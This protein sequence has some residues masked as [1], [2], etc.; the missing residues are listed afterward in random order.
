MADG[1]ACVH[2][3]DI[4]ASVPERLNRVAFALE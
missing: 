1:G 2:G 4:P 3:G